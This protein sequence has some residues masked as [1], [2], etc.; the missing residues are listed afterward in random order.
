MND[1][2]FV[3]RYDAA[4]IA[5]GFA[6]DG[7][8]VFSVAIGGNYVSLTPAEAGQFI[9]RVCDW[10]VLGKRFRLTFNGTE[11]TSE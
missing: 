1:D 5:T 3:T 4:T 7:Q 11:D 6:K 8:P 2:A 10:G 9:Q